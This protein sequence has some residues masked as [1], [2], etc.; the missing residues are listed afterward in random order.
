MSFAR[1]IIILDAHTLIHSRI[2]TT[3]NESH[4]NFLPKKRKRKTN[5]NKSM[6]SNLQ[7]HHMQHTSS[8]R[9]KR[10]NINRCHQ[11][12]CVSDIFQ[13]STFYVWCILE[14]SPC[15]CSWSCSRRCDGSVAFANT[16]WPNGIFIGARNLLNTQFLK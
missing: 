9:R 3:A 4:Q 1:E 8:K 6:A 7:Q 11:S 5:G 12:L 10:K 2:K 16:S 13:I 15:F 14:L